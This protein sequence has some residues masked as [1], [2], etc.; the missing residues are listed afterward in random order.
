MYNINVMDPVRCPLGARLVSD[1]AVSTRGRRAR[2]EVLSQIVGKQI[3]GPASSYTTK[4]SGENKKKKTESI[5][6]TLTADGSCLAM[7]VQWTPSLELPH[8][9]SGHGTCIVPVK[10]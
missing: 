10:I 9:A 4:W 1:P 7:E 3:W 8:S 6:S 5:L 2:S